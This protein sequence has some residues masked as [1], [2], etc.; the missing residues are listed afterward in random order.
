MNDPEDLLLALKSVAEAF[1]HLGTRYYV[2]GSIASSF[3]GAMRSTMD[4]DLLCELDAAHVEELLRLI[5]SD[6][7]ASKPAIYDAIQRHS[8]FN[9]IHLPT[10]FKVDVFVSQ[11]RPFDLQVVQRAELHS[12]VSS[13]ELGV[14]IATVEDVILL[15]LEWYRIGGEVSQ[16]QWDDIDRLIQLTRTNLDQAYL[17]ETAEL[18]GV[19]DL[20]DHWIKV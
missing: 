20:L 13:G 8:C 12:L 4:V 18:V 2:G 14:P 10:S 5:G 19:S 1:A 17:K 15:K 3:H 7:Y 11:R 6:Y 16:R 9:L